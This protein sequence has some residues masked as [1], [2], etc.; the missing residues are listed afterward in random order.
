MPI[1]Y[2]LNANYNYATNQISIQILHISNSRERLMGSVHILNHFPQESDS[3]LLVAFY[4]NLQSSQGENHIMNREALLQALKE[5]VA[6]L[7]SFTREEV[8]NIRAYYEDE[9]G[10]LPRE[11]LIDET[12]AKWITVGV[13][14]AVTV[15]MVMIIV[16]LCRYVIF[17]M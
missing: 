1:L 13:S 16:V 17:G 9:G 15:V 8:F 10:P 2:R 7:S 12:L 5:S 14:V 6:A 4:V 3:E 11:S